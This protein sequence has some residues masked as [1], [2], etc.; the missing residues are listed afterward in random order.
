MINFRLLFHLRNNLRHQYLL[1]TL[2][3]LQTMH[4]KEDQY[5]FNQF[6]GFTDDLYFIHCAS[7]QRF[8]DQECPFCTKIMKFRI[9]IHRHLWKNHIVASVNNINLF[10]RSC[11]NSDHFPVFICAFYCCIPR[12]IYSE[13]NIPF[14]GPGRKQINS[15]VVFFS[16]A[17]KRFVYLPVFYC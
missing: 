10:L 9:I 1:V 7:L 2:E 14:F 5:D 11:L 16:S 17:Q 15:G 8:P 3:Y 13:M 4:D 12:S 6:S